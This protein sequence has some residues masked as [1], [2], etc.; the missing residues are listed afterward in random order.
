MFWRPVPAAENPEQVTRHSDTIEMDN[1]PMMEASVMNI[2]NTGFGFRKSAERGACL[3]G[4]DRKIPMISYG[5][6]EY[7]MGLE[8]SGFDLLELGGGHSTEFWSARVRSVTTLETDADWVRT[9]SQ[10]NLLNTEIRATSVE[11]IVADMVGLGRKFDAVIVDCAANR[12][13][14]AKAALG[15]LKPGG[16]ILL[17]NAH[18]YPQPPCCAKPT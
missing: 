16:F 10:G 11:N 4:D 1:A 5:L 6:I 7:L 14:C 17:D 9:L 15:I 13:R 2:L 8:L 12:Y 3:L 18:W